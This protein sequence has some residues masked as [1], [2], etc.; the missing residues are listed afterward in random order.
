[1]SLGLSSPDRVNTFFFVIS[2]QNFD[3]SL[4]DLYILDICFGFPVQN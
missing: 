1:M 3:V 2:N 4:M